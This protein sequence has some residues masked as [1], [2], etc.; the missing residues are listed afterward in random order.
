MHH[1]SRIFWGGDFFIF[2]FIHASQISFLDFTACYFGCA[3]LTFLRHFSMFNS[4]E[5]AYERRI[6]ANDIFPTHASL[7]K[8]GR[9]YNEWPP[10]PQFYSICAPSQT[11]ELRYIAVLLYI[12]RISKWM[13]LIISY[14]VHETPNSYATTSSAKAVLYAE[15]T[16]IIIT[17]PRQ[18]V[19][20]HFVYTSSTT[21]RITTFR[22]QVYSVSITANQQ[23][24]LS[25][26]FAKTRYIFS[27]IQLLITDKII[28]INPASI[29]W[30]PIFI[31]A[32]RLI[33]SFYLRKK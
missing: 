18:L 5:Y 29:E 20:R 24:P 13:L 12:E 7:H 21:I 32:S 4:R 26:S 31:H 28:F 6:E 1:L 22:L 25:Y 15:K 3:I 23:R 27:G 14:S 2:C 16:S 10:S 9:S 8:L 19:E 11:A 17:V 30:K 33:S